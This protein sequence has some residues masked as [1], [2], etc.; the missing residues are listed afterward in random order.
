MLVLSSRADFYF[1]N[2][3]AF[4]ASAYAETRSHW[5]ASPITVQMAANARYARVQ[6][7][8]ATNPT[9]GLS[10]LGEEFGFGESAAYLFFFGDDSRGAD[11]GELLKGEARR[12]MVEYFFGGVFPFL[13][14]LFC[15]SASLPG[16]A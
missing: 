14:F 5:T 11:G 10:V 16:C 12:E 3:Y 4:N 9:F 7:S 6:T 13:F 15:L 1:G 2:N 8:N